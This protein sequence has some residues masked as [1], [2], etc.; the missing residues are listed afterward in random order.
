MNFWSSRLDRIVYYLIA[1]LFFVGL[2]LT[3]ISWLQI[4]SEA[5]ADVH[6]Y[7]YYGINFEMIGLIFFVTVTILHLF[8]AKNNELAYV[9]G[10]MV[11]GAVGNEINF[12]FVQHYVIGQ[13]CP[14]CLTIAAVIGG[15]GLLMMFRFLFRFLILDQPITW[16]KSM[17]ALAKLLGSG[18]V[19][20]V[21][22]I[23][24]FYG[25]FKP[26]ASFADGMSGDVPYF[27]NENSSVEVYFIS[28]WFCPACKR[29]EPVLDPVYPRIMSKARLFFIDYPIHPETMNYIPYNLSFMLNDKKQYFKIRKALTKLAKETKTPSPQQVQEAVQPYGVTY[30][31]LNFADVNEGI[32]FQEGIVKTFKVKQTPTV[33][34]ANRKK[35]KAKKL[36]GK[37]LTPKNIMRAIDDMNNK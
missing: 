33:V 19:V 24:S 12:V 32:K 28:D 16:G 23:I 18:F 13:W 21:A 7:K 17:K 22:Y 3:V 10:L 36:T 6:F 2:G 37:S 9:V 31:P 11:A 20:I 1:L 34:V 15:I 14:V 30:V 25:V 26:E 5:C 29:V 4:C 8:S 35:L 27:G